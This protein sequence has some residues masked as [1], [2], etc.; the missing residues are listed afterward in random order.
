MS[1][2][3][4]SGYAPI[5][6]MAMYWESSGTGGTPVIAVPGGFGVAST[7]G[8]LTDVL[9]QGRRVVGVELQGHGHTG[10]IQRPF[11]YEAF[12][13]DIGALIQELGFEQVDLVG[14]SLGA[15]ACLRAAIQHPDRVRRLVVVSFPYCRDGWFP[16][17]R[18][19]FDQ[20]G[21]AAFV[22][23]K[24]SPMYAAWACVAPD[25]AAFPTVMDKVGELQRQPYDWGEE[26]EQ[27][28]SQTMLVFAD[29][30]SIDLRHVAAFFALV[31]GGLEDPGVDGSGR[32]S[33]RLAILPAATHYD[34]IQL[35]QLGPVV[36]EF[37][38]DHS[39]SSEH[40]NPQA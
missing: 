6:G 36:E 35:P 37:L 8:G 5:N 34:I 1:G 14:Y 21:S 32:S 7:L 28:Q 19:A 22:Y 16:S 12:G 13:D 3:A 10:D 38:D 20:M 18:A 24:Q 40:A 33:S 23:M 2:P 31:G 11:S 4:A 30:D 39:K 9:S 27:L 17:V 15:G 29:A 26:V 25:K